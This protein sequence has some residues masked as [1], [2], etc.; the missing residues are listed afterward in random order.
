[1][2]NK[3]V[4]MPGREKE[5]LCFPDK[6]FERTKKF[7]LNPAFGSYLSRPVGQEF[8]NYDEVMLRYMRKLERGEPKPYRTTKGETVQVSKDT[9]F[10]PNTKGVWKANSFTLNM[11]SVAKPTFDQ[12]DHMKTIRAFVPERCYS[13]AKWLYNKRT[14]DDF[15][16]DHSKKDKTRG[17]HLR[18]L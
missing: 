12:Y 17:K 10:I 4:Y 7:K 14:L 18:K 2:D 9:L 16:P 8:D 15:N 11:L 3:T 5:K 1:M 13:T 6:V